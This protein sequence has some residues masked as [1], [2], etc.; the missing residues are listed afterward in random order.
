MTRQEIDRIRFVTEH[1]RELQGL[2]TVLFAG[3]LFVMLYGGLLPWS[4]GLVYPILSLSFIPYHF[5]SR[6]IDRYYR[7]RFGVVETRPAKPV[8]LDY[9][10]TAL[11][12]L[13]AYVSLGL[14][15]RWIPAWIT[16]WLLYE[17]TS[18]ILIG[19]W[20]WLG[21]PAALAHR[22]LLGAFL[23]ALVPLSVLVV[24][25]WRQSADVLIGTLVLSG[26]LDHRQLE[27]AMGRHREALLAEAAPTA[28]GGR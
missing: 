20:L 14:A 1:F 26:L 13:A 11:L 18:A 7:E 19:R 8:R 9:R 15:K 3:W 5:L 27:L 25:V 10:I 24:P 21:R 16:G 4:V 12:V 22:A 6:R 23:L 28:E 17:A 2:R